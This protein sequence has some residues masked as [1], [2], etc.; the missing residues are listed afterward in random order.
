M[1]NENEKLNNMANYYL[2]EEEDDISLDNT[3]DNN[4]GVQ[5]DTQQ[6][7][8][9]IYYNDLD[10]SMR[11]KIKEAMMTK[12][13]VDKDDEIINAKIDDKFAEVAMFTVDIDKIINIMDFDL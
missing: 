8:I 12:M 11:T 10:L 3:N 2:T 4:V 6:E 9:K 5:P 1:N 7:V 13:G